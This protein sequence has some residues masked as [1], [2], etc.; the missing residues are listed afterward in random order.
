MKKDVFTKADILLPKAVFLENWSVVACDQ[1]SSQADY[2]E[3]VSERVGDNPSTYKMIIP[4]AFLAQRD[5]EIETSNISEEMNRYLND[6]ILETVENAF[7][8]VERTLSEGQIR[9]GLVGAIDLEEYSFSGEDASILASEGTVLDRL[10]A[11][12]SVRRAVPLE[13]THVLAFIND[14]EK[15]VIEP[16]EEKVD[17]L[18]LLYEF[19]LMEDGGKIR[20][21]CV[22]GSIA[23]DIITALSNLHEKMN[24][25]IIIGDGNHSLAAAKVYWD[26]LKQSLSQEERITHPARKALLEINN[27]YDSA[28]GIEAIHRAIFNVDEA[29]FITKLSEHMT[30]GGDYE[31]H[32]HSSTQNETISVAADCIGDML[33]MLQGFLDEYS[34]KTGS[35]IDYIH[36]EETVL[37]LA[38][39]PRCVGLILP[40]MEKSE[41]FG[42]VSTM[43]VFPKKSFSVG[44]AN[45]KRFYL[46]CRAIRN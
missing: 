6:G 39:E 16:L 11:R 38:K 18:P 4:E 26:E 19:E 42:T 27:V 36:G 13:S 29:D 20:G 32:L 2:W 24:P 41:L 8:Y 5:V 9:R 43:G 46:E 40:A 44:H 12:I 3:R 34:K 30:Q 23:D 31:I 28:I 10:P 15:T 35:H 14:V 1:Y 17:L 45:E 7:I 25:L 33:A 22:Q 37:Q 21:M